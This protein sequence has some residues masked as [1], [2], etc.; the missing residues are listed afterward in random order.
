MSIGLHSP[1]E[2]K[3]DKCSYPILTDEETKYQRS[4][5]WSSVSQLISGKSRIQ[6]RV[7]FITKPIVLITLLSWLNI[8]WND[9]C[10]SWSSNTLTTWCKDS[11]HWKRP[12]CWERLRVGGEGGDKGW[13][14]WDCKESDTNEQLNNSKADSHMSSLVSSQSDTLPILYGGQDSLDCSCKLWVFFN[15]VITAT[16]PAKKSTCWLEPYHL[17]GL[18]FEPVNLL[19]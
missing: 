13:D 18:P 10:W 15:A 11:T 5:S 1:P 7:C 14:P 9:W 19:F 8:H 16:D 2:R 17:N 6:S 12:W 3:V 4:S